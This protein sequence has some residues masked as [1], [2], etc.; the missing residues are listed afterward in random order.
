MKDCVQSY[1]LPQS[2]VIIGDFN[3]KEKI[4]QSSCYEYE[5]GQFIITI[6]WAY[7][8]CSSTVIKNAPSGA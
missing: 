6:D 2:K 4:D 7:S 5:K 3:D 1:N 8:L